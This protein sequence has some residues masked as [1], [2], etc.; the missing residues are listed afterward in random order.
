VVVKSIRRR[1]QFEQVRVL[2]SL[3]FDVAVPDTMFQ[4]PKGT[5]VRL[6]TPRAGSGPAPGQKR[7]GP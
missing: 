1:P 4:L 3:Q 5:Q 6:I 2:K 7:P